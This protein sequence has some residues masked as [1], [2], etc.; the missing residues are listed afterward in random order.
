MSRMTEL[1]A[2][3]QRRGGKCAICG[4]TMCLEMAHVNRTQAGKRLKGQGRTSGARLRDWKENPEDYVLLCF[5]CHTAYDNGQIELPPQVKL[6][7][8]KLAYAKH[9]ELVN[10]GKAV[11]TGEFD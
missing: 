4:S 1:E 11:Y 7:L 10:A 8:E 5:W 6:E 2:E 9:I 3:R